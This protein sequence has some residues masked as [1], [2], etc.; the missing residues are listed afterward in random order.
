M[1]W[2]HAIRARLRLLFPGAAERRMDEEMRFHIEMETEKYL[3]EGATPAEAR[4]RAV[5]AFGGMEGHKE[6]MREGR[7]LA[8]AGGLSLDLK[9]AVRMLRK[10]PWL[11]LIGG[12]GMALGVGLSV[13]LF[14]MMATFAYPTLPLEEG[15]RIV[16]LENV[17][18]AVNDEERP[19]L[20]D[21]VLW[22]EE[23]RSVRD[24]GGFRTVERN[25]IADD[26]GV[27][28]VQ[29]A[30]M[31]A[32]GFRLARV[33]PLL[34]RHLVPEDELRGAPPVVVI[35]YDVW[36]ERFGGDPAVVG[37]GLRLDG[38]V[39]TVVG[40]MPEGFAFPVNHRFWI[41]LRTEPA[42]YARTEGPGLFVYGRLAPGVAVEQAQGEL[43][44]IGRRTAAA[45]P[46]T[47]AQLRPMISPYTYPLTGMERGV[48]VWELAQFQVMMSLLLIVVALNVAVLVYA[49]T[50]TRWGEIAV[51]SA[52]GASRRR[53]VAQLF[54]EA[55]VLSLGA[56]AV[57][58]AVAQLCVRLLVRVSQD[59]APPPFWLDYGLRPATLL[60]TIGL[61]VLAAVIV[62]VL[63]A[64]QATG[65]RLQ[66][67][68]RQLGGTTG[69]RLGRTWTTLIVAQVAIAVAALPAAINIGWSTIREAAT[70]PAYP[71]EEF[72]SAR[73]ELDA[74]IP[75][76]EGDASDA[77][78]NRLTGLMGRLEAEPAVAGVT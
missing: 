77:F 26:G 30:E 49:R 18:A 76:A 51:R 48:S 42:G 44:A 28:P 70:R 62:G 71:A 57:G 55:L 23:L 53:I 45:Y 67:D 5:L 27:A 16:A 66:G 7:T 22:R 63:P 3:R 38:G 73:L 41:P 20:H 17:N 74:G 2:M 35:G 12:T 65:S 54:A 60:F 21:L 69:I 72:L 19:S 59:G 46:E 13:G 6:G 68:L 43:T 50:A 64:L 36:Q 39:H 8:W 29:L 56:A 1:R 10:Y 61:A 32:A 4:R 78:A 37:R 14:T 9:L 58:F 52:L 47:H 75:P 24:L 11:T 25:L 34:G 40:V 31:T 15:D 33:P